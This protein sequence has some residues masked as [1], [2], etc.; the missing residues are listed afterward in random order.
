MED[1]ET[2][3]VLDGWL[4]AHQIERA[5]QETAKYGRSIWA[6]FVKLGFLSLEDIAVFFAQ[7][8]GVPYVNISDYLISPEAARL[9]EEDFCRQNLVIPL[10]KIKGSLFVACCNPLDTALTDSLAKLAGCDIVPLLATSSS[11]IK[12]LNTLYGIEDK[13]FASERFL[14]GQGQLK[15]LA[16]WRE[17]ERLR[18][19]IP[20]SIKIE[21]ESFTLSSV[22]PIDGH[23]RDISYSGTAIGLEVFLFLPKGIVVGLEFKPD[24][25]LTTANKVTINVKGEIA[26]CRMEKGRHYF[27]GVRFTEINDEARSQLFALASRH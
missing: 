19:N 2:R 15:G 3:L 24:K 25:N 16:F 20:V 11:I 21:D 14:A 10:F 17:S 12:A 27:L 6:M 1:L 4:D 8:S 18:L 23:T 22:S 13:V 9:I 26:Y 7:E 5:R